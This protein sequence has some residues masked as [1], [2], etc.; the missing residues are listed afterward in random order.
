MYIT[1]SSYLLSDFLYSTVGCHPTRCNEFEAH[2]DP[3]KYLAD[4]T[5]LATS[6]QKVV[7]LGECGLGIVEQLF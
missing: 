3:D 7:A 5:E 1:F 6:S 2:G 4:L